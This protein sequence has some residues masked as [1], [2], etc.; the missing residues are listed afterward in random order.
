MNQESKP[1]VAPDAHIPT[2]TDERGNSIT[3]VLEWFSRSSDSSDMLDVESNHDMEEDAKIDDIDVEDEANQKPKPRDNVYLIIPRQSEKKS[4]EVNSQF[5]KETDWG[6]EQCVDESPQNTPKQ[7][8]RSESM[9]YT[10]SLIMKPSVDVALTDIANNV[11]KPE[12]SVFEKVNDNEKIYSL[13][14]EDPREEPKVK[15]V[16]D[17]KVHQQKE[18]TGGEENQRPKLAHLRS[19]WERENI[20]PKIL[21]SRTNVPAKNESLNTSDVGT[22]PVESKN[23]KRV[24]EHSL[25]YPEH[26]IKETISVVDVSDLKNANTIKKPEVPVVTA[27]SKNASLI[28]SNQKKDQTLASSPSHKQSSLPRLKSSSLLDSGSLSAGQNIERMGGSGDCTSPKESEPKSKTAPRPNP[29]P[30]V[31]QNSQQEEIM[32]V[33]I[34][35]LKSFWEKEKLGPRIS[36]QNKK[37]SVASAKMNR[38]FTKSEFDLRSIGAEFDDDIEDDTSDREKVSPNFSMHPL[39]KERSTVTDGMNNSQFK[40]LRDFWGGSPTMQSGQKSPVLKSGNKNKKMFNVQSE[41]SNVKTIVNETQTNAKQSLAD[42][43]PAKPEK[44]PLSSSNKKSTKRQESAAKTKQLPSASSQTSVKDTTPHKPTIGQESQP[45]Q[46]RSSSKGS[47]NGKAKAMR[48]ASSMFSV[49][50]AGEEQSQ[51]VHPKPKE[52]QNP[53]LHQAT[54][55]YITPSRKTTESSDTLP[56]TSSDNSWQDKERNSQRKP[57]RTSEDSDFQPLARSYIPPNYQ[58]YLGITET[59]RMYTPPPVIDQIEDFLCTSFTTS[60]ETSCKC[61]CSPVRTSTPVQGSPDLQRRGSLGLDGHVCHDA[62]KT[63]TA[64]TWSHVK[65]NLNCKFSEI[66]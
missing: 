50:T 61:K 30:L 41:R 12:D 40:N 45:Q 8:R 32:A 20:G 11:T 16:T 27:E 14:K 38:R 55:C 4:S 63:S 65:G 5:L 56:N 54:K 2:P 39:W 26:Q 49:N 62:S 1:A 9:S 24:A 10:E 52:T 19:F 28:Y 25:G 7:R 17:F 18:R 21:I 58:H 13:T 42:S 43:S 53:N 31:K 33:K 64:D 23:E 36:A 66:H 46:S 59:G 60:M 51:S 47:L 29:T 44:T 35:Q 22:K 57:S 34:K 15:L 3:K 37:P 6:K 48:R